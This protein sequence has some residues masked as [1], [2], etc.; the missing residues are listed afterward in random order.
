MMNIGS[1][2]GA[3]L[4][5]GTTLASMAMVGFTLAKNSGDHP[6][7]YNHQEMIASQYRDM[8]FAYF[9][10]A[11]A[12][13]A[14]QSPIS[15]KFLKLCEKRKDWERIIDVT[16]K[17]PPRITILPEEE[18]LKEE[19]FTFSN[20][21]NGEELRI[22]RHLIKGLGVTFEVREKKRQNLTRMIQINLRIQVQAIGVLT[23][24]ME[25]EY[26]K[27]YNLGILSNSKFGLIL[28]GDDPEINVDDEKV[29]V[30][31]HSPTFVTK[32][33]EVAPEKIA[34]DNIKFKKPVYFRSEPDKAH[35]LNKLKENFNRGFVTKFFQN[36]SEDKNIFPNSNSPWEYGEE[37]YY[38]DQSGTAYECKKDT[39]V[40]SVI[41]DTKDRLLSC[42]QFEKGESNQ[43]NEIKV[44]SWKDES[45]SRSQVRESN[46]CSTTKNHPYLFLQPDIQPDKGHTLNYIY[47]GRKTMASYD[48]GKL[49]FTAQQIYC[50]II[51]AKKLI[52]NIWH[53]EEEQGLIK[54]IDFFFFGIIS[55]EKLEI[56]VSTNNNLELR[57][58]IVNPLNAADLNTIDFYSRRK[59]NEKETEEINTLQQYAQNIGFDS[60]N[61]IQDM[62]SIITATAPTVSRNFFIPL[63]RENKKGNIKFLDKLELTNEKLGYN[64]AYEKTCLACPTS[65]TSVRVPFTLSE[66]HSIYSAVSKSWGKEEMNEKYYTS[67]NIKSEPY[68]I[69]SSGIDF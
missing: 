24:D 50:G 53:N 42:L 3:A 16:T 29:T 67:F 69:L 4:L 47:T 54:G 56:N 21:P 45:E 46:F 36:I 57:L 27:T 13:F 66:I 15:G 10:E 63:R 41:A 18:C 31:I 2:K 28:W 61:F 30:H 59:Y 32:E 51:N 11:I 48:E 26:S 39:I 12:G 60:D 25:K 33:D 38:L 55:V 58:H 17:K 49:P 19:L 23:N 8:M 1:E 43:L 52:I 62:Q 40:W 44:T 35:D 37:I 6:A 65:P 20:S 34:A 14:E 64:F 9:E 22:S 5:I 68:Y 7:L